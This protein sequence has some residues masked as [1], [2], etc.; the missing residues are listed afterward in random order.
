MESSLRVAIVHYWLNGYGGGERVLEAL[1]D[2]FPNAHLYAP[3]AS[4]HRIPAKLRHMPLTTSFLSRIPGVK[5]WHR[6]FLP[7]YP[8]ALEQFDLR[9]YDLVIS[10]ESGPAKGVIT[11][12]R[13]C[14]VCYCH[15][16]MR[17]IWDMYHDY[18]KTMNPV[19]R[20]A[21]SLTAHYARIWDVTTAA[22]VDYFVANSRYVASRVRK[23]YR[24]ESSVIY[25][26]ADVTGGFISP[27]IED[28]YLVVSRLVAYKRVDLAIE[29]CNRLRRKLRVVGTG[30]EYKRLRKLAGRTVE[31]VGRLDGDSLREG[32]ARCRALIFP[33]QEDFGIAPVEAQSFGRPVIAYGQG[34]A[35][36]TVMG[37]SL[38]AGR[39]AERSTGVFFDAQSLES[40]ANAIKCFEGDESK[41]RPE[42]IRAH[43]AQF[44]SER[45]K[46]EFS[47]FVTEKVRE[48]TATSRGEVSCISTASDVRQEPIRVW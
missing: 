32:Y 25:P 47:Q 39:K 42:V 1:A 48:F 45:F 20:A 31:F 2:V 46:S 3:V 40:L 14:H 19:N 23:Y 26:P 10:S 12:P 30:P 15:T 18:R 33:A 13:T 4:E 37:L 7:L 8:Y 16:P 29:A 28:Y 27:T 36:E 6:H 38:E 11:G 35:L 9:G 22:R 17:Y 34:G 44:G 21:F 41:F 5:R 24:R 43:V